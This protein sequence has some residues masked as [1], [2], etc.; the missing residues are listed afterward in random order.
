M[1]VITRAVGEDFVL[2][3]NGKVVAT[4]KFM[5]L[6]EKR[7]DKLTIG[8]DALEEVKIYRSELWD[9]IEVGKLKR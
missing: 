1:L 2:V 7:G 5:S 6:N 8:V 4:V 9:K 3:V